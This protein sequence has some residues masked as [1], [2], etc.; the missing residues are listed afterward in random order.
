MNITYD[1]SNHCAGIDIVVA[2]GKTTHVLSDEVLAFTLADG[3]LASVELLDTRRFGDPF[4]E[5]AAERAI[6]WVRERL[7]LD[8]AS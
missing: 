4:D 2:W 6:A 7:Q 8:A 3:T 5:A 1:S